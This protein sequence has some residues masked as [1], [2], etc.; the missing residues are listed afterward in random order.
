MSAEKPHSL[1]LSSPQVKLFD[2]N[3]E[4]TPESLR[5]GAEKLS[6]LERFKQVTSGKPSIYGLDNDEQ[7]EQ[8]LKSI[9]GQSALNVSFALSALADANNEAPKPKYKWQERKDMS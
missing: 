1:N 7:I 8:F 9:E 3:G 6:P 4:P 5:T 2:S